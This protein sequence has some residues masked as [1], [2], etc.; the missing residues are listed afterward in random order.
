MEQFQEQ[1]RQEV[2]FYERGLDKFKEFKIKTK[3]FCEK[4]KGLVAPL[5]DCFFKLK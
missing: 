4:L 3:G 2:S 1:R 5:N